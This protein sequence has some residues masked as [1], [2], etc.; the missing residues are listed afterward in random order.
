[1]LDAEAGVPWLEELQRKRQAVSLS[2]DLQ[3]FIRH[4]WSLLEPDHEF[5]SNWHIDQMCEVLTDFIEGRT[6][7][8][9]VNIP[10]GTM[11]SLIFVFFR[12][13]AWARNPKLRFLTAAYG[14]HLT[15]RDN[16]RVRAIVMSPE[17][18]RLFP[19]VQMIEDQNT[20]TRFNTRAGGWS[21]ATSV[22]GVGTGEHPDF[23]I[24]DD[25]LTAAQAESEPERT[26]ANQWFTGTISSRGVSRGVSIAVIGQRL[27]EDDLPGF[28]LK[29]GGWR[30]ICFPMRYEVAR[31]K[32]AQDPGHV[33]DP[34]DPRTEAGELLWPH[35]FTEEKVRQ[36]ELDLGEYGTAGQL[37][38]R[39]SPEGGGLFKREWFKFLETR[40][41]R[42]L[43]TARGW[44][45]AASE[46]KGDYTVGTLI[47]EFEEG[48]WVV[49]DVQRDRL[50]PAGVEQLMRAT[51]I[52][53]GRDTIV[54]EEKE[55]GSAGLTVIE[56]RRTMMSKLPGGPYDYQGVPL[57]GDK[58][59]R[60]KPLRIVCEQGNLYLLLAPWNEDYIRELCNFPTGA[61]DDQV[62]SS[63]CAYNAALLEPR[64]MKEFAVW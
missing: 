27:H 5:S 42:L 34:L 28:L 24:I 18:Q 49:L 26:S 10:P 59:T 20:K 44:D 2:R 47:G 1:M 17:Y 52:L 35:L 23:I 12:A 62:D 46:G 41:K 22:G 53:D 55:G 29:K 9:I 64:K 13:W 31:E 37:Q 21:I 25:A 11:K 51:T 4:F 16:L 36:L 30:H 54:R 60:A 32:T 43:R 33:P 15:T 19:D 3:A 63:S 57:S 45:T 38:Q 7:R 8:L 48:K 14:S 58:R 39:P 61:H 50:G 56:A 40:P 6:N